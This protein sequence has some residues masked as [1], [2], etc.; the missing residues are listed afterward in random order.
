MEIRSESEFHRITIFLRPILPLPPYQTS[1]SPR[2]KFGFLDRQRDATNPNFIV[3]PSSPVS[4]CP[5]PLTNFRS[6]GPKVGVTERRRY[7]V[8]PNFTASLF[9]PRPQPPHPPSQTFVSSAR[10]F[11]VSER[12][13]DEVNLNFTASPSSPVP[14][15]ALPVLCPGSLVCRRG[16]NRRADQTTAPTVPPKQQKAIR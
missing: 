2:R 14:P 8:N 10:K 12:R 7:E 9:S 4:I 5:I 11:G 3:F 6:F 13:R 15:D 16:G 1:V